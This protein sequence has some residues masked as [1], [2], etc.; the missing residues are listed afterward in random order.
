MSCVASVHTTFRVRYYATDGSAEAI[1]SDANLICEG[2]KGG[3]LA[4]DLRVLLGDYLGL[5]PAAAQR[6]VQRL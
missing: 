1:T 4:Q 6:E 3:I 2:G 5:Q